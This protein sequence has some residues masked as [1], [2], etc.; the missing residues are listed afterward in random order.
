MIKRVGVEFARMGMVAK[1]TPKLHFKDPEY[2]VI[3]GSLIG[4]KYERKC[5]D[6]LVDG[7][8]YELESYVPPFSKRKM[9]NMIKNGLK[10]SNYII[11]NNTKGCSDRYIKRL[12]EIHRKQTSVKEVWL[13]EKGKIRLLYKSTGR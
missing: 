11:I 4:T 5:P 2:K 6:L 7:K 8:F 12:L 3:Y 1:A 13:Y 10:Q 9:G